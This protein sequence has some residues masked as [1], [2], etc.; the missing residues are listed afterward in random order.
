MGGKFLMGLTERATVCQGGKNVHLLVIHVLLGVSVFHRNS[1]SVV[2][3]GFSFTIGVLL[4]DVAYIVIF[5][6]HHH[7]IRG[8]FL[9]W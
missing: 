5:R 2:R 1:W 3:L 8:W 9:T 7:V 6:V 4:G